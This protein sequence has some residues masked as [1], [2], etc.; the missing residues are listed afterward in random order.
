MQN[1]LQ[2]LIQ[3]ADNFHKLEF[4]WSQSLEELR[5]SRNEI[6][7][8]D[9]FSQLD[10]L[11]S[12]EFFFK[13]SIEELRNVDA[14]LKKFKE[15]REL[16]KDQ[17]AEEL[18]NEIKFLKHNMLKK[19]E[20][21]NEEYAIDSEETLREAQNLISQ[22]IENKGGVLSIDDEINQDLDSNLFLQE[23]KDSLENYRAAREE[24]LTDSN[25]YGFSSLSADKNIPE[26]IGEE[27]PEIDS[28]LSQLD[29]AITECDYAL[30]IREN[31][32]TE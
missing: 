12:Y 20:I 4:E 29:T 23:L 15:M 8:K 32:E 19:L 27:A 6:I 24:F 2:E 17:G 1:S 14:Q 21:L 10:F 11:M 26:D 30:L 25:E 16:S 3:I 22:F 18:L 28:I 9:I 31:T 5:N 7:D 13:D